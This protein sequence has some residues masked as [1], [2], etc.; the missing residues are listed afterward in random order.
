MS[1]QQSR[2]YLPVQLTIYLYAT[3]TSRSLSTS[4]TT[5]GLAV[6]T[7]SFSRR[8]CSSAESI[9]HGSQCATRG[10]GSWS[11]VAST[12][13]ARWLPVRT[14]SSSAKEAGFLYIRLYFVGFISCLSYHTYSRLASHPLHRPYALRLRSEVGARACLFRWRWTYSSSRSSALRLIERA[15]ASAIIRTARR[16]ARKPNRVQRAHAARS[17]S[18]R[19]PGGLV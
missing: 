18:A 10:P 4:C 14:R 9:R 12:S 6:G 1:K 15:C 8:G 19:T 5:V 7:R 17:S 13:S 11:S 3:A 2:Y 16:Y